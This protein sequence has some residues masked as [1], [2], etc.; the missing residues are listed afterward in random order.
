MREPIVR[1]A[2][3][4]RNEDCST[5][6]CLHLWQSVNENKC[7]TTAWIQPKLLTKIYGIHD[8][9][10][11]RRK[12][13][14]LKR[15]CYRPLREM[16]TKFPGFNRSLNTK[17]KS[18]PNEP[19]VSA[20]LKCLVLGV[21]SANN[22][23]LFALLNFKRTRTENL[24]ILRW[25]QNRLSQVLTLFYSRIPEQNFRFGMIYDCLFESVWLAF[26]EQVAP[27]KQTFGSL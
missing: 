14:L 5:A 4:L 13:K 24:L 9:W 26:R 17:W 3:P 2:E 6:I 16:H 12:I 21:V 7:I 15:L 11:F 10:E 18:P 25:K 20:R 23:R 8:V 27:A 22:T 19:L 1:I